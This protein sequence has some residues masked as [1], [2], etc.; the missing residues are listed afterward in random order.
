MTQTAAALKKPDLATVTGWLRPK[1][2]TQGREPLV[3]T[4]TGARPCNAPS[5]PSIAR[6]AGGPRPTRHTL[7]LALSHNPHAADIPS[8]KSCPVGTPRPSPRRRAR[9]P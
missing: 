9:W 5:S 4:S 2:V 3:V 6:C 7:T 1:K 8:R